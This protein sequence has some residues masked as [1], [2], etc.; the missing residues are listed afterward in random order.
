MTVPFTLTDLKPQDPTHITALSEVW[1]AACPSD[2]QLA[3][4]LIDF[5]LR[6]V[7]GGQQRGQ[8][9]LQAGR[10]VGFVI[11]STLPG[12]PQV[13]PPTVG[14]IDVVAVIP[15]AQRQGVGSAL[16][17]WAEHWLTQQGCQTLVLGASQH[18]FAPGIPST[19]DTAP[20][21]QHRGYGDAH[22]TWDVSANLAA[23]QP[24][25]TVRPIEGTVR[26][27]Q[28][29]DIEGLNTFFAREFPGR[30]HFEFEEF[31]R[32]PD[33]RLSDYMVL[34]SERGV[35]GFCQL[36]FEDSLRPIERFYPY[37]LPRRWGQ[38]GPIGVSAD[39]RGRG[40]G[41]ALLDTGLRRL[42]NNGVNGCIID[43]TTHLALYG[44][45]GFTPYREYLQLR[46]Q[47]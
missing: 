27:A 44:K 1:N 30:W 47:L 4:R 24:P 20:F 36:T 11:A 2:V 12:Q 7:T 22:K 39:R 3:P 43:W 5:N 21:F 13:A 40:Y 26:P 6:P 28:A 31:L 46:K 8:L 10:M 45:F 38:L 23:Y 37:T 29:R 9:A 16:L 34:W 15:D 25:Q 17:A 32:Q 35:D 41:A 33:H 18:P 42:Y 19:L 14:W